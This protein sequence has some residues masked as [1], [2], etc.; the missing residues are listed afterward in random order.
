[1]SLSEGD[2]G[3]GHLGRNFDG[4]EGHLHGG[5]GLTA[6]KGNQAHAGEGLR[7]ARVAGERLLVAEGDFGQPAG[8][9][10]GGALLSVLDCHWRLCAAREGCARDGEAWRALPFLDATASGSAAQPEVRLD[11]RFAGGGFP[12]SSQVCFWDGR[13]LKSRVQGSGFRVQGSGVRS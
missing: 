11:G 6:G 2:P 13:E 9:A 10:F 12:I 4:G 5:F 1:V 7:M 8:E 3:S